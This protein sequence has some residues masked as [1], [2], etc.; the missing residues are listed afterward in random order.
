MRDW[1]TII[2][3][4]EG[5]FAKACSILEEFGPVRKS[6]FFN[7]LE[8]RL[9]EP[10]AVLREIHAR[11]ATEPEI[12]LWISRFM[13]VERT[14][15]F[16]TGEQFGERAREE[17]IAWLPRLAGKSFHLRMH[18]RGFKGR[19]SSAE[20]ERFLDEFLLESLAKEGV[21]GKIAFDDPD[22]IIALETVGT[23]AGLSLWEREDLKRFPLLH[24]D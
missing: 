7:V 17:I 23:Q 13:P 6:G 24:L 10:L 16:N 12:T 4:H 21:Q 14:F 2:T 9:E 5:C 3:V 18:R 22:L 20:E 15:T 1:N 11:L 8:M 19:I